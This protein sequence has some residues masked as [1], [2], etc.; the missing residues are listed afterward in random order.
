LEA[1]QDTSAFLLPAIVA[2]GSAAGLTYLLRDWVGAEIGRT[3]GLVLVLLMAILTIR[4]SFRAA[5]INH[6]NPK[7]FLVYAHSSGAVKDVIRQAKEI[8]ERT[9]GGMGVD[10]AYDAS[11]PDTGVSWPFVWYLRDFTNQH[12][13]DQPTRALRDST[14]VIVDAKNFDKI[15]RAL[16]PGFYRFDYMRMWWPNQDYFSLVSN[17]EPTDFPEDYPCRGVLSFLRLFRGS[18]FTRICSAL[19]DPSVRGGMIDIWLNR[20]YTAYAAAT[21]HTDMTLATWQ[22]ADE[23]RLYIKKDVAQLVWKYGVAPVDQ[24]ATEVDPYEGKIITLAA[25][26]IIAA[27][28]VSPPMSA[29]RSLAF[30]RDGTFY[31]ADS[32]NNRILHFDQQGQLLEEWGQS[33]GNAV[34]NPNPS[35]PE[36]TFNEPWGVAVGRDGSVYVADTWNYRIQK[37]TA[38][39]RFLSMWSTFGVESEQQ[40][41]Y[42]P[43]G[44]AVDQQGRVYIVDTG[45]KRI[46][47]FDQNGRYITQFGSAGLDPGQFDEP[48]GIAIGPD[49]TV[50]VADVWNQRIQSF[51]PSADG[52]AFTPLA[53]WDVSGWF[54]QSLDNKPFIALNGSGQVL[55]T[56]PDGS[57][58]IQ[59]TSDGQLVQTWGDYGD[60]ET[61][62]GIAAGI[63]V[64]PFGHVWVTDAGSNRVMRFTLP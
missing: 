34:N 6:D 5:F 30:A 18:D 29:P 61:T 25:E 23:M 62:F 32:R 41:F 3:L 4:A 10:L 59:Y 8:S 57:R 7:E 26:P 20:D 52:M 12:S 54:G 55:V 50:F 60:T 16:G 48:V 15:E 42:G 33:S 13:F 46:V 58:V 44:L 22:P 17:R 1:L 2:L 56:D 31:V 36:G 38:R 35:A 21:G 27:G 19:A 51:V 53:Q 43:R 14:V 37:F 24:T 39:G 9:T 64:D 45:N 47:I 28:A 11:A 40:T 49:G 63:A